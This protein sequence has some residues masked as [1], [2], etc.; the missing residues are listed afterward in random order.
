[1]AVLAE[2]EIA[3]PILLS[4]QKGREAFQRYFD[5][6]AAPIAIVPGGEITSD[7]QRDLKFAGYDSSLPWVSAADK[8]KLMRSSIRRQVMKQTKSMSAEQQEAIMK[9]ALAKANSSPPSV[10]D[11][12]ATEKGALTHELGHMWFIAA[13]KPADGAAGGGHG[14]G[15]WAPD[16]L[17]ETAAVL[18]ENEILTQRRRKAFKEMNLEDFYPLD[19][20]LTME[21][22]ALKSAQ[23]L[24]EKFGNKDGEGDSRAII[25]TGEDAE[26]FLKTSGKSDPANFYTQARGF[27][28][29]IIE[30]TGDEQIFAKLA[31]HLSEGKSFESWLSQ[32]DSLP[33]DLLGLKSDWKTHL[34]AR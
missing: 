12:S 23:A 5:V 21:H 18:L 20:F 17:D 16:W 8:A 2:P 4:A 7:L 14:Y 24:K 34:A 9:M 28:D 15:G 3:Q 32:T 19:T 29:F 13:F 10:G 1:M 31:Q 27:A 30:R 26:E 6:E 33:P 22:P 25:L 11:M